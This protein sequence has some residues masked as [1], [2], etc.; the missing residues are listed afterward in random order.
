LKPF[1][2]ERLEQIIHRVDFERLKR[3]VIV[4]G[5]KNEH[6]HRFAREGGADFE[7]AQSR[8]LHIQENQVRPLFL[9]GR[10]R[11]PAIGAFADD[12]EIALRFQ[13][14]A[15]ARAR[16]SF[17]VHNERADFHRDC[18][19]AHSLMPLFPIWPALARRS[20]PLVC[21]RRARSGTG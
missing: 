6:R 15:N 8:H 4:G 10:N 19:P 21:I 1:A 18:P 20:R 12:F 16:W 5:D 7:P 3:V 2:I 17:V 13:Q 9:N 11:L 14:L